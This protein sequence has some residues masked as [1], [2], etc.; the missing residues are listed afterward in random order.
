MPYSNYL[1]PPLIVFVMKLGTYY[2]LDRH[3]MF[4]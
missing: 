3:G 2:S 4:G 1:I